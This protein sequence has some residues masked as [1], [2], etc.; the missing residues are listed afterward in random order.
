MM[1][2]DRDA[3]KVADTLGTSPAVLLTRYREL[4]GPED[5]ARF[6]VL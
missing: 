6:W 2:R 3:G 4:V 1:A 5:A